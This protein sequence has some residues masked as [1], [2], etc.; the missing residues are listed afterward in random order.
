MASS[1]KFPNQF[2]G[3]PTVLSKS[4]LKTQ[5]LPY[6]NHLIYFDTNKDQHKKG[7]PG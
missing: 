7:N 4:T 5:H 1:L 2:F 6:D 3:F